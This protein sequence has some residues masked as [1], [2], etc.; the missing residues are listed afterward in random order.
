MYFNILGIGGLLRFLQVVYANPAIQTS[1]TQLT[2]GLFATFEPDEGNVGSSC[3]G[4][5][6]ILYTPPMIFDF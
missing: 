2:P 4:E 1:Q 5:G 6:L 3:P